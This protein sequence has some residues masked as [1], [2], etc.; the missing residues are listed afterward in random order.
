V[1]ANVNCDILHDA[2]A[3]VHQ[4]PKLNENPRTA[5]HR[6]LPA[7]RSQSA[8]AAPKGPP[9]DLEEELSLLFRRQPF[10]AD[11]VLV[12]R[13]LPVIARWCPTCPV[14]PNTLDFR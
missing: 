10:I 14:P 2:A 13:A 5:E 12:L 11:V 6:T 8:P 4:P 9:F 1:S 3:P 7:R